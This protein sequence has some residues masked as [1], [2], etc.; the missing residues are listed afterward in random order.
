[1][2]SK[3]LI[4]IFQLGSQSLSHYKDREVVSALTD[5]LDMCNASSQKKKKETPV[6]VAS[7]IKDDVSN[8]QLFLNEVSSLPLEDIKEKLNNKLDFPN[9]DSLKRLAI[10]FG[11]G[12]QLRSNRDNIIHSIIKIIERSRIDKTIS[13]RHD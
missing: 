9:I 1:M 7:E 2:K 8:S 11:L 13:E 4:K 12:K 5:I 10:G 6:V 3:E